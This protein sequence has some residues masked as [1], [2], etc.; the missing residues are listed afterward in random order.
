MEFTKEQ[1]E[2]AA[3]ELKPLFH[4]GDSMSFEAYE[5]FRKLEGK[6]KKVLLLEFKYPAI[7][8]AKIGIVRECGICGAQ[9]ACMLTKT[10]LLTRWS[11]NDILPEKYRCFKKGRGVTD[12]QGDVQERILARKP[13]GMSRE[14][15][16]VCPSCY[17]EIYGGLW[18]ERKD[19]YASPLKWVNTHRPEAGGWQWDK[20]K[21]LKKFPVGFKGIP[22]GMEYCEVEFVDADGYNGASAIERN[23]EYDTWRQ[24][25]N[26]TVTPKPVSA[27][28]DFVDSILGGKE[29]LADDKFGSR[30][31]TRETAEKFLDGVISGQ[32]LT[33]LL[34]FVVERCNG[35]LKNLETQKAIP[36]CHRFKFGKYKGMPVHLVI[37]TDREYVT[38]VLENIESFVLTEDEMKH[39]NGEGWTIADHMAILHG[40]EPQK[41][42]NREN[43]TFDANDTDNKN[44]F[45]PIVTDDYVPYPITEDDI[46]F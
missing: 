15:F 44:P 22:E 30:T 1:L 6:V 13:V 46:P 11:Q 33:M 32:D 27:V 12:F 26:K 9:D 14:E 5:Y 3:R 20:V 4:R 23:E 17:S 31:K 40:E 19:F 28:E 35:I 43:I 39:Y 2:Q 45:S 10:D 42:E 8:R 41:T 37:E 7:E 21:K 36:Y 29:M 18:E 34:N 16:C 38:W 24:V 25:R